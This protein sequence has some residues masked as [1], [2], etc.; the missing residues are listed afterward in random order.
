VIGLALL[1]GRLSYHDLDLARQILP[2]QEGDGDLALILAELMRRGALSDE[3]MQDLHRQVEELDRLLPTADSRSYSEDVTTQVLKLDEEP[4]STGEGQE[5]EA[6]A[7][8]ATATR[9]L[10]AT[11]AP[12]DRFR[13]ENNRLRQ[14]LTI[15]KWNNYQNLQFVGEGGMGRIF[16]AF[17]PA[18]RRQVALKFLNRDDREMA[19]RLLQEAQFQAQVDHPNICKVYEVR[20]WKGQVYVA[21]QYIS[22]TRL[23]HLAPKLTLADKVEIIETVTRAV[24]A[25][26]RLGLVHRDL[27]PANIMVE[28][29]DEGRF[30]PY[31]LDFGL[32]RD[33]GTT[34][35]TME[36][37]ILGTVHY[38]APEQARGDLSLIER[39]TDVYA[40]GVMLYELLTGSPPFAESQGIE[41]L[42]RIQDEDIRP[43]RA[44]VP[45]LHPDLETIV[46]KCL[47]KEIPRRYESARA[48]AED[49]RRFQ[50][51]D[52]I[53]ARRA[54]LV[55][56][57]R[58]LI[59]KHPTVSA[60]LAAALV[61]VLTFAGFGLHTWVT[62]SRQ[63]QWAQYFGQEAE[64]IEALLRYA[65][66]QPVHD[67]RNEVEAVMQRI[68]AM[69]ETIGR[70]GNQAQGPGSYALGRAYLAL[71]QAEVARTYLDRAWESGF[72]TRDL[73]YA[74]GRDLSLLYFQA[75]QQAQGI[76]DLALRAERQRDLEEKLKQPAMDLLRQGQGSSLEPSS[77]QEGL[78][79]R[80]DGRFSEALGLAKQAAQS[81]PWFYEAQALTAEIDME[82]SR[83]EKDPA[84]AITYLDAA[85]EALK[86]ARST[87]P[88]DARLCDL[89][90]RREWDD[91][92][93]RRQVGQGAGA[94]FTDLLASCDAWDRIQPGNSES[95]ARRA[96]A[97]VER[98]R[99][100]GL[101][102][103]SQRLAWVAEGVRLAEQALQK[104]PEDAEALGA[105]AAGIRTQAYAAMEHGEDPGP[106]LDR[107]I[108]LLRKALDHAPSA[109]EI[110]D[111][112]ATAYWARIELEKTLGHD[113]SGILGE[114]LATIGRVAERFPKVADFEGYLGG[115]YVELADYESSRGRDPSSTTAKAVAHFTR[116]ASAQPHRF[117]FPFGLGNAY[118]TQAEFLVYREGM[119]SKEVD[120]AE[121]AYLLALERN[122]GSSG[123][124]YGLAETRILRAW[125]QVRSHASPLANLA[126]AERDLAEARGSAPATWRDAC[127]LAEAKLARARFLESKKQARQEL[128]SAEWQ[129]RRALALNPLQLHL[130]WLLAEV[131]L[132]FADRFPR[133]ASARSRV[134][135]GCLEAALQKDPGFDLARQ[136]LAKL[137]HSGR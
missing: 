113:P 86:G 48:L 39:R 110:L 83:K 98:S 30:K 99:E 109:F 56:R 54:T 80:Y 44:I 122:P 59:R 123:T 76:Q 82:R 49:L 132:T 69:E 36:G 93:L 108:R 129:T 13:G 62:A 53:L 8:H 34:G 47:E 125:G 52:P 67:V 91:M 105:M 124:L 16:R 106:A 3:L 46:M 136:A 81:A 58:K 12:P 94:A 11:Q 137:E 88:S 101:N 17:D 115:F 41:C 18:L 92:I 40:L 96:W 57:V 33:L 112:L 50:D 43:V 35:D 7:P 128:L 77:F 14:A 2:S 130:Q 1:Q 28:T 85:G 27:K 90:S 45:D 63:A 135:R 97:H 68:R 133:E 121:Q 72:R 42:L 126:L 26:H 55:D 127:Y 64:R 131:Q 24:Q 19:A 6:G 74:R 23:D 114:A 79:A 103:L 78:L 107:A 111:Q 31:V 20:E 75:L 32:A 84:K 134:A 65:R 60:L 61:A 119:A 102:P 25:A 71:G 87:A 100:P 10:W 73:A 5:P 37:T 15:P 21:M 120:Q 22:G 104:A 89:D 51:G 9:L 4:E 29:T 116:A 118:L 38:M 117:E 95:L 66:L 70:A